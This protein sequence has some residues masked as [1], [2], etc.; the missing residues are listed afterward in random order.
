MGKQQLYSDFNYLEFEIWRGPAGK[1]FYAPY[2]YTRNYHLEMNYWNPV[3]V[4]L[5]FAKHW[6]TSVYIAIAYIFLIHVLQRY[7]RTRKAWNL[8]LPLCLW[9][10]TL[11]I[12]SLIAT[13][14]FGEEFYNTLTTRP[15]LHSVCYSI[16]PFQPAAVWAFAFAISKFIELGDTIF[17]LLRKKALIF[18][19]CS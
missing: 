13:I 2:N 15:F 8:R 5:F 11:S 19:H 18:L 9:N 12:F 10:A 7:Q 1:V 4:Q 3:A 6:S 17:L 14:R 16:S